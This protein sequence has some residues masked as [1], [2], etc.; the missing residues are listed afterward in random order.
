MTG[1]NDSVNFVEES[2]AGMGVV[3]H[4]WICKSH[5][6]ESTTVG[7]TLSLFYTKKVMIHF[8][9]SVLASC[10]VVVF[11]HI[12]LLVAGSPPHNMLTRLKMVNE[13]FTR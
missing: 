10:V 1:L 12:L 4:L 11:F 6:L 8:R 7:P 9:I 5:A 3:S 2:D 13:I